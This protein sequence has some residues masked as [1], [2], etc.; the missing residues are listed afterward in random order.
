M[1]NLVKFFGDP[2]PSRKAAKVPLLIIALT[3]IIGFT[4][5]ACG[6][7]GGGKLSGTYSDEYN[8]ATYIFSEDT[9]TMKSMGVTMSGT[10]KIKGK[11]IIATFKGLDEPETIKY[12]LQGDTL[13]LA[14]DGVTT[15]LTKK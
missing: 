2:Q 12:T 8:M 6:G 14:S 9:I 15:V 13:T 10:F 4:M 7:G 5:V 3:A 1:K 11:N